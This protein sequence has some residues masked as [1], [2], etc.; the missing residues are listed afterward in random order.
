MVSFI[1]SES[2]PQM[3]HSEVIAKIKEIQRDVDELRSN[4]NSRSEELLDQESC[5]GAREANK[6]QSL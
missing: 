2:Q 5:S 6:P 3:N 4:I 1:S